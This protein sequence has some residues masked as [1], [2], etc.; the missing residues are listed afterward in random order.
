MRALISSGRV[1]MQLFFLAWISFF[2]DCRMRTRIRSIHQSGSTTLP[3]SCS[4]RIKKARP[5]W[6]L[7]SLSLIYSTKIVLSTR[8]VPTGHRGSMLFLR[9]EMV[10][11]ITFHKDIYA[12]Q[13]LSFHAKKDELLNQ[14]LQIFS[15]HTLVLNT[16]IRAIVQDSV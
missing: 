5:Q 1:R 11:F 6:Q 13:T 14:D 8:S 4:L 10:F 3:C 15:I 2:P 9:T 12:L 7:R 16:H